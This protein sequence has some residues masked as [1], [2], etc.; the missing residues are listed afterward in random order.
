MSEYEKHE[1]LIQELERQQ[2]HNQLQIEAL[3]QKIKDSA[4]L[5]GLT[6][7]EL[8]EDLMN[9]IQTEIERQLE[10]KEKELRE[11]GELLDEHY[12]KHSSNR[13]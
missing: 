11:I 1:K 10:E 4:E 13:K 2:I 7:V 12:E 9:Q 3:D 6:V 5:L 8:D